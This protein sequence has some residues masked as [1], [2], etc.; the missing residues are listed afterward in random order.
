MSPATQ[1]G[2]DPSGAL[3]T[4]LLISNFHCPSCIPTIRKALQKSFIRH[5]SWISPNL[6]T[7]VVTVEHDTVASSTHMTSALEEFGFEVSAVATSPTTRAAARHQGPSVGETA[8]DESWDPLNLVSWIACSTASGQSAADREQ[9]A[10]VHL[11][12]CQKCQLSKMNGETRAVE[13]D[14]LTAL[15]PSTSTAQNKTSEAEAAAKATSKRPVIART[16]G[17]VIPEGRQ[18]AT[19]AVRGMTCAVV[20]YDVL[21]GLDDP[22]DRLF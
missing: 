10:K 7:S 16:P 4:S 14:V 12:S 11:Q 15:Q 21:R 6:I 2:C 3:M 13:V 22:S 8:E 19:L 9:R 17:E 20:V 1:P 18:R 5:I